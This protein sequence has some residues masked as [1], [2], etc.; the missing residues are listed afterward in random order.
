MNTAACTFNWALDIA[1]LIEP[2]VMVGLH[3]RHEAPIALLT[4]RLATGPDAG[5]EPSKEA[6]DVCRVLVQ[7]F[8]SRLSGSLHDGGREL[9]ML[10]LE[11]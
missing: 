9:T 10:A 5:Y 6:P 7:C 11:S 2:L 8:V 4:D 1:I 3:A